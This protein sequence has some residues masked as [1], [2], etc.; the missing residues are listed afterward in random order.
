MDEKHVVRFRVGDV[1]LADVA[2]TGVDVIAT[3][4]VENSENRNCRYCRYCIKCRN[5]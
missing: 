3:K 4:N 1:V 2:G 5:K